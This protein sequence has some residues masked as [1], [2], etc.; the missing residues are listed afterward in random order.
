MN[1]KFAGLLGDPMLQIGLGIL[2]N[3]TGNRGAF[4]PAFGRGV[5][6][7]MNNAQE[8]AQQQQML[9]LREDQIANQ[10]LLFNARAQQVKAEQDEAARIS[11][12]RDRFKQAHPEL[13]DAADIDF[14]SAFK[15]ANPQVGGVDPYF[16]PVYDSQRGLGAFDTRKGETKW[17]GGTPIVK[18]SDDP[19][20]QARIAASKSY[21]ENLYQPTDMQSGTIKTKSQL[22]IDAGAPLPSGS[23]AG[24]PSVSPQQQA[25]RDD[26]RMQILLAEQAQYGGVGKNPELDKEIN[27]MKMRRGSVGITVPTESEKAAK[28]TEAELKVKLDLEPKITAANESAKL[29]GK[30]K[31]MV[32]QKQDA[33]SSVNQAL[34]LLDAGIYTGGYA[35]VK[36]NIAKY[37]PFGDDQRLANT[38]E[39][40]SEI[41]NTVVPRLQEFGGNDSNEE[42]RYL[43]S[44]MGGDVT[45]E[46][47]ALKAVLSSV[48]MKIERGIERAANG[49]NPDGTPKTSTK[50]PTVPKVTASPLPAKPSTMT[51]KKG[52]VYSTPQGNLRWNGKEF[53]DL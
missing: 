30:D 18:P 12:A 44:I 21:G 46:P 14:K 25:Q 45:V 50:A 32:I 37:T 8:F 11:Q 9:K 4:A 39:F 49:M 31:G 15:A 27:N 7:G 38:Q 16:T 40:V 6:Q 2:A 23:P 5:M 34:S 51:L 47:Q 28:K 53:E 33:L 43:K 10:G 36:S 19:N 52:T 22:A 20:L 13:A 1:D 42:M 29:E 26:K 3:N 24:Y 17:Q 41:G 48:K 35:N